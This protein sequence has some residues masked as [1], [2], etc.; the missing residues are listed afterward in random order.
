VI[1]HTRSFS[2]PITI[3]RGE[4]VKK[5]LLA[6]GNSVTSQALNLRLDPSL[7]LTQRTGSGIGYQRFHRDLENGVNSQE[8]R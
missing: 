5:H 4:A 7:R 2:G 1:L 3:A 6:T 8:G